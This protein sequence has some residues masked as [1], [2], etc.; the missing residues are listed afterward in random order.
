[1]AG[2]YFVAPGRRTRWRVSVALVAV[3]LAIVA[4]V[5]L[6]VRDGKGDASTAHGGKAARVGAASPHVDPQS[7][8][9]SALIALSDAGARPIPAGFLGLSMEFQ[10]LPAY[11]GTDPSAINPVFTHLVSSLSP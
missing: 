7:G 5:L 4:V 8:R 2:N 3:G 11:A 1:M 10:A 9:V 6:V